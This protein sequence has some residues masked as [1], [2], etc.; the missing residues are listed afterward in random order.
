[1]LNP[2]II[3]FFTVLIVVI[4]AVL[5]CKK[6]FAVSVV[7]FLGWIISL[8][9]AIVLSRVGALF[10]YEVILKNKLLE[11]ISAAVLNSNNNQ[12]IAE[13]LAEIIK[14]LPQFIVNMMEFETGG[15]NAKMYNIISENSNA[16]SETILMFV[17]PI[18]KAALTGVLFIVILIIC[19]IAV[20]IITAVCKLVKKIPVL[21][22]LDGLMGFLFGALK[23]TTVMYIIG[24]GLMFVIKATNNTL[25]FISLESIS[26]TK[27]FSTLISLGKIIGI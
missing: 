5:A 1:M 21:G 4:F 22:S 14:T 6:G 8:L 25:P 15:I 23:G 16:I 24:N 20:K 2:F 18:I 3:D 9:A 13:N 17:A 10:I 12:I 27:I 26:G 11:L 7:S 19:K